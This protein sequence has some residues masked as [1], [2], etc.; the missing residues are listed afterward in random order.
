[1]RVLLLSRYGHLG[2]S[3]RIRSY[4]YLPYLRA[5]GIDV[6]CSPLLTDDYLRRLYA[7]EKANIAAILLA[8]LQRIALLMQQRK[9]DCLWVEYERFPWFPGW[10]ERLLQGSAIPCLVD[11]DDAI[12]HRYD[13]HA[14][15]SVRRLLG[16][17]ID[18]VM[19]RAALVTVGNDYLRE[20]AR[21]AGAKKIEIMPTSIDLTRYNAPLS[22]DNDIFTIGWI[23]SPATTR[24]LDQV[25]EALAEVCAGGNGR[26]VLVGASDP[27]WTDV[28]YELIPWTESS[29]VTEVSRFDAGIMPLPDLPWE[30]G[31]CGY[32]LIQYMGCGKPVVA[33]PVGVNQQIVVPGINGYLANTPDEW[34]AALAALRADV[35]LCRQMGRAGRAKVEQVYSVQANAPRLADCLRQV[36][37]QA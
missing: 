23:G 18:S 20:R 19:R 16:D 8:Y 17:K 24:Y 4:Q 13:Q 6:T 9:F 22:G 33:S 36:V 10:L 7:G 1:M 25:H 21:V 3:S 31:K 5:Q 34:V 27:G 37:R 26:V 32:K 11:Y 35:G 15:H 30:K 28:P 12:F 29:E 2:A 14:N